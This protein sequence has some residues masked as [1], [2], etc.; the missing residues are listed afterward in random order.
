MSY[1]LFS[2]L[3]V[4]LHDFHFLLCRHSSF[5]AYTCTSCAGYFSLAFPSESDFTLPSNY[6]LFIFRHNSV[7]TCKPDWQGRSSSNMAISFLSQTAVFSSVLLHC[8]GNCP[9]LRQ[10]FTASSSVLTLIQLKRKVLQSGFVSLRA[11]IPHGKGL[12]QINILTHTY[13]KIL[14][15]W[16][17]KVTLYCITLNA[18]Q[19]NTV[20]K[21]D[22]NFW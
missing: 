22:I 17:W 7:N 3:W 6:S 8:L 2:S 11:L 9:P 15:N 4:L 5:L 10:R 13:T 21:G 20:C 12:V 19:M 14:V 16:F 1:S 18:F